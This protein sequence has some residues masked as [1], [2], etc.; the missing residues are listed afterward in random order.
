[1]EQTSSEIVTAKEALDVALGRFEAE[2][3]DVAHAMRTMNLSFAQ[4]LQALSTLRRTSSTSGS[5]AA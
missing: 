2:H 5:S 3:P 4:Y 1:M